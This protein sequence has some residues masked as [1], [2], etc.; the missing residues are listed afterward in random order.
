[1]T[2]LWALSGFVLLFLYVWTYAH[3]M[4]TS[5]RLEAFQRE[6]QALES[7]VHHLVGERAELS[8]LTRIGPLA[9]MELGMVKPRR[10]SVKRLVWVG[11]DPS[12]RG[13][14]ASFEIGLLTT[15]SDHGTRRRDD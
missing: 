12:D 1:M 4:S 13:P 15:R 8:S 10:E 7:R 2:A 11:E 9:E 14:P 3:V 6:A 5:T